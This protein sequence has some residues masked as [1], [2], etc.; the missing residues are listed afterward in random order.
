MSRQEPVQEQIQ[1]RIAGAVLGAFI[2]DTL[3]LGVHWIYNPR[4][5]TRVIGRLSEPIDPIKGADRYHPNRQR[6][7]FTHFG[8]QALVLMRSIVASGGWSLADFK[9]RW[10][11]LWD[12]YDGYLDGATKKTLQSGSSDSNDLSG[13]AR[14]APLLIPLGPGPEEDFVAAVR[15]QTR[16]SHGDP[17]NLEAGDFFARLTHRVLHGAGLEEGI[18]HALGFEY[19]ELPA[20]QWLE[21]ARARLEDDADAGTVVKEL[22][23]TCHIQDAYPSTLYLLLK[24]GSSLEAALIENAMAGGDSAARAMVLGAVLGARDGAEA[25][26]ARWLEIMEATP[27]IRQALG[28]VVHPPAGRSKF[29]FP[30]QEGLT[31]AGALEAPDGEARGYAVFAH[32]FTCGKDIAAAARIARALARRGIAVLRFDFTG[33][34][35]SDGDFA[36]TH[37]SSNVDDLVAA[38]NALRSR[39][40]APALLIGHSLGGAAVLAAASRIAEVKGVVTIGAPAEPSHVAH[41]LEGSL[42]QIEEEGQA[43]VNLAGRTFTIRKD[44]LEDIEQHKLVQQIGALRRSLLVMH[45]PLDTVVGVD[46]AR[47]IFE[48][49]KHPKSF[50]SLDKADHLLQE[51]ADSEFVAV[52]VAGWADRLLN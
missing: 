41:L 44:F 9:E 50:I 19:S 34:G 15:A 26:P 4:H 46:N 49:A 40:G 43:P 14:M 33:L 32:C 45:S 48:A 36:N 24:Y 38:A 23:A 3:S 12:G 39:Y 30:N 20:R 17:T 27:E 11:A 37:F 1:E 28:Q 47:Q 5:I 21:Q 10:T 2:G 6:G 22:G 52:V 51:R 8:D 16:M 42:Q 35:N 13:F 7:Q 31:L 18:E 25:I 29:E